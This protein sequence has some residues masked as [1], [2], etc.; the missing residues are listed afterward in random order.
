MTAPSLPQPDLQIFVRRVSKDDPSYLGFEV[1]ALDPELDLSFRD[2]GVV[3]LAMSPEAYLRELVQ[4][5]SSLLVKSE[6]D[7]EVARQKL[8]SKGGALFEQFLPEKLRQL[9]W[10]LRTKTATLQI[11]S[12]DPHIPWELMRL[13]TREGRRALEG[14]FLCE[15]FAVTRWLRGGSES[16]TL[17]IRHLALV[18]PRSS[19]LPATEGEREDVLG[20]HGVEREVT[21]IPA[22][23]LDVKKQFAE[24]RYDAWHFGGHGTTYSD[25]PGLWSLE[26]D[27]HPL[28]P[29]DMSSAAGNLVSIR[30]LIFFNG[31]HTGRSGWTLAGLGGWP[32]ALLDAGAGAFIGSLWTVKD[33][34][35]R[36]FA[37]A[38]YEIFLGG[39]P[40]GEA[41]RQARL[42]VR[43]EFP[44]DPTWLAYTVFAHPLATCSGAAAAIDSAP[45]ILTERQWK[46]RDPPGTLLQAEFGVVP[47]HGREQEMADLRAWCLGEEPLRVR[48]YTGAGGM[49]KTRLALEA[50]R[51]LRAAGWRTGF[52][53]P[54]ALAS[55]QEAWTKVA[56][57]GGRVLVVVDYAETRREMLLPL[58]THRD[59]ARLVHG[60]RRTR[61]GF[62]SQG[63]AHG[64]GLPRSHLGPAGREDMR[65]PGGE[66]RVQDA[67]QGGDLLR[68]FQKG[69]LAG[70][71][72]AAKPLEG[73]AQAPLR[74]GMA[75]EQ[76]GHFTG[77]E[78]PLLFA[79]RGSEAVEE[80][81]DLTVK[82]LPGLESHERRQVVP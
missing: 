1:R 45:L 59:V 2:Y 20:L 71:P 63:Q 23:Y 8:E 58:E 77:A 79:R 49:G 65:V 54:E 24:G 37:R 60:E 21:E 56:R 67:I 18:V 36:T 28:R 15:A 33:K 30:P 50:A 4:D 40:M 41:V 29:E 9:L 62:R 43:D 70:S 3:Q 72:L 46:E 80:A 57:P 75:L 47:F 78:S 69:R 14:P 32:A 52:L 48:L 5:I 55:P 12:D 16:P 82:G 44:G 51:A 61:R 73:Q 27:D 53:E 6:K 39:Q 74:R 76:Q 26:L 34:K 31:C 10:S 66:S 25:D 64:D 35:A 81:I 7:R 42:R 19:G 38:F 11:L 17:P 13:R 68:P 22:R